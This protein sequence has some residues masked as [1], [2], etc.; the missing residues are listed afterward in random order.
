MDVHDVVD[1]AFR[2]IRSRDR[3]VGIG[4]GNDPTAVTLLCHRRGRPL[5]PNLE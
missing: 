2:M 5:I 1:H 3:V 4:G